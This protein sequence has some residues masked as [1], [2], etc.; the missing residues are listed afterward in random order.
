MHEKEKESKQEER[1][2]RTQ[3]HLL[4]HNRPLRRLPKILNDCAIMPEI[5]LAGDEDDGKAGAE[6]FYF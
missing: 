3:T 4:R 1:M 5:L 6:M 2:A